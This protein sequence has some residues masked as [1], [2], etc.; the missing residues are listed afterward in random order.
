MYSLKNVFQL[1]VVSIVLIITLV[2]FVVWYVAAFLDLGKA[3]NVSTILLSIIVGIS[4]LF[5]WKQLR[6]QARLTR[7]ANTQALV[8]L[9]SPFNMQLIQ[10][11]RTAELWLRGA[12]EYGDLDE[13]DQYRYQMLLY[14]WLIFHEN[15]FYQKQN[16]LLDEHIFASWACD[17][18]NFARRQ[19]LR[20]H[21]G[22]LRASFQ[23]EFAGHID[24]LIGEG[25]AE[26]READTP[27][28]QSIGGKRRV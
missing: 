11:R 9:S 2:T 1:P 16:G 8:G 18:E 7:V 26:R 28:L 21:W 3:A 20:A 19:N 24:K 12:H 25:E 23:P 17:L 14:W 10:E 4:V 6:Q 27:R 22:E 5:I 13:V 15:V